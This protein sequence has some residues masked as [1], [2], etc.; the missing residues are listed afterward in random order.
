MYSNFKVTCDYINRNWSRIDY[1]NLK[2]LDFVANRSQVNKYNQVLEIYNSS[3][4][5]TCQ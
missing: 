3:H 2:V 1:F 5:K 4:Q